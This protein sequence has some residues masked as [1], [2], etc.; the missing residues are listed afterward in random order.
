VNQ[1]AHFFGSVALPTG[2]PAASFVSLSAPGPSS[3]GAGV[4]CAL[5]AF[6]NY[7]SGACRGLVKH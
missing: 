5:W 6:I 2:D 4:H 1:P 7:D 3:A